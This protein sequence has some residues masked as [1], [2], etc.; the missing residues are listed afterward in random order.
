MS[1]EKLYVDYPL[2]Y[3]RLMM[4]KN[5]QT[6]AQFFVNIPGVCDLD[7]SGFNLGN[8]FG[9]YIIPCKVTNL[10]FRLITR[11]NEQGVKLVGSLCSMGKK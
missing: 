3:K 6:G 2:A 10:H 9:L 11:I 4:F 8:I 1:R 5:C 7:L